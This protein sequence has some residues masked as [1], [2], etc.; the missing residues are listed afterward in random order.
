M[1]YRGSREGLGDIKVALGPKGGTGEALDHRPLSITG[2]DLRLLHKILDTRLR[3][4]LFSG[5]RRGT[6]PIQHAYQDRKGCDNVLAAYAA[7]WYS[8]R[9]PLYSVLVDLVK[10]YDLVNYDILRRVLE[11]MEMPQIFVEHVDEVL[12]NAKCSLDTAYGECE[13]YQRATGL[14]QGDPIC[15]LLALLYL[16]PVLVALEERKEECGYQFGSRGA[17]RACLAQ[18]DDTTMLSGTHKGVRT[19][20]KIMLE[21]ADDVG[22]ELNKI[23]TEYIPVWQGNDLDYFRNRGEDV[24]TVQSEPEGG[25]CITLKASQRAR[26]LGIVFNV[27]D[28]REHAKGLT[29]ITHRRLH[30]IAEAVRAPETRVFYVHELVLSK[31]RFGAYAYPA[32]QKQGHDEEIDKAIRNCVLREEPMGR[33][34]LDFICSKASGLN[35]PTIKESLDA[36]A[37]A[38]IMRMLNSGADTAADIYEEMRDGKRIWT[39]P[40]QEGITGADV[41]RE[42]KS[43]A[44]KEATRRGVTPDKTLAALGCPVRT[45]LGALVRRRVWHQQTARRPA[46]LDGVPTPQVAAAAERAHRAYREAIQAD[47]RDASRHAPQ[48]REMAQ[49]TVQWI[50]KEAVQLPETILFAADGSLQG[51][52]RLSVGLAGPAPKE[53]DR[54]YRMLGDRTSTA[55][56]IEARRALTHVMHAVAERLSAAVGDAADPVR[57]ILPGHGTCD[58]P[59]VPAMAVVYDNQASQQGIEKAH[60]DPGAD[61][62]YAS[63]AAETAAGEARVREL[64]PVTARWQKS[65]TEGDSEEVQL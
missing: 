7:A 22:A 50:E 62:Q 37:I 53:C 1:I 51:K 24:L 33:E 2:C 29:E 64:T 34:A 9:G 41:D 10:M 5:G 61:Q 47:A 35:I 38:A 45:V 15:C 58:G 31:W 3:T 12:R 6:S 48:T 57:S 19:L 59:R 42:V 21:W 27:Q 40:A 46:V 30:L 28:P 18:A 14:P 8:R 49:K 43:M 4:V 13:P 23:K 56:E 60:R 39:K 17:R 52:D 32:F 26:L 20:L 65:H 55:P 11:A 36:A 54:G 16:Q 25:P 63:T 44:N